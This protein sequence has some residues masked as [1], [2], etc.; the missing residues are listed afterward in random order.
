MAYG[1]SLRQ[2]TPYAMGALQYAAQRYTPNQRIRHNTGP[3][4]LTTTKRRKLSRGTSFHALAVKELPA[5]HYC[6]STATNLLH[7]TYNTVIPSAGI[8]Q[9]TSNTTRIADHVQLCAIKIKGCFQSAA[10]AAGFSYRVLVG[11]TGEEYNL[12]TVLGSGLGSS[13]LMI[14]NSDSNWAANGIINP[15]A[16]T[17]LHDSTYDINSQIAAVSDITSFAMTV[18]LNTKLDYQSNGSIYGKTRNLAVVVLGTQIG[19]V[20]GT[21][22]TGQVILSYDLIFK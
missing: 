14:A 11:F 9:G 19:G 17:V 20:V 16:F 22:V 10:T 13:E 18:P 12:P 15:K 4:S 21:T 3:M 6:N 8:V 1:T 7:G 2:Y 5:K